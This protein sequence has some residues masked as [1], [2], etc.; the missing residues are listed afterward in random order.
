[1][2]YLLHPTIRTAEF[3][4]TNKIWL[5]RA[6]NPENIITKVAVNTEAQ[7][8]E[9]E[10][11]DVIITGDEKTGVCHPGYML[12]SVL[13]ANPDD[14]IILSS[15]DFYPPQN[16]DEYLNDK[17]WDGLLFVRDGY[18]DP[19]VPNPTPAITIPIMR[20]S[21][22]I[23]MNKIIYHPAYTHMCSD[24]ELFQTANDLGLIHDDR[25][26]DMTTFQH[27]H[28]ANGKREVDFNDRMYNIKH[29]EDRAI[30][31]SR[32]LLSVEDRIKINL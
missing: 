10:G 16:W 14:I 31:D 3:K 26:T 8:N 12:S 2:I 29:Q 30:F 1:M 5:D 21:A 28:W 18:Q 13:E 19:N 22:L 9:L 4:K 23:K 17:D 15:D 25:L 11:F 24:C 32:R 27:H 7:K 20:F 6:K